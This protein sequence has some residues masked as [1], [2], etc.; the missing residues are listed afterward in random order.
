MTPASTTTSA[1]P[2][3]S[4]LRPVLEQTK[5]A[6][7]NLRS[8]IVTRLREDLEGLRAQQAVATSAAHRRKLLIKR[9]VGV[10]LSFILLVG[11]AA[12]IVLVLS[13]S[14]GNSL[15]EYLSGMES[16]PATVRTLAPTL[17]VS[18]VNILVPALIKILVALESWKS[19][20][21]TL[22]QTTAR[23]FVIKVCRAATATTTATSTTTTTSSPPSPPPP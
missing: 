7:A 2:P 10:S 17:I 20:E 18:A 21:T 1:T 15:D 4:H 14:G 5:K 3:F 12:A 19:P 23:I 9:T 16:V 11:G 8:S 13:P 22:Q 6:T